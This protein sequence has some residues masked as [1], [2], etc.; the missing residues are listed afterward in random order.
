MII[1]RTWNE[2]FKYQLYCNPIL[3][4]ANLS[5]V[6]EGGPYQLEKNEDLV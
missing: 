2:Y 4:Q 6:G 3:A 5:A 1:R